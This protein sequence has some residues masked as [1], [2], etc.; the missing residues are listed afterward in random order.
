MDVFFLFLV[1]CFGEEQ[2]TRSFDRRRRQSRTRNLGFI[3]ELRRALFYRE[4]NQ[5]Q[6][7]QN[8]QFTGKLGGLCSQ[9]MAS[10]LFVWFIW[11]GGRLLEAKQF[12]VGIDK[13][14]GTHSRPAHLRHSQCKQQSDLLNCTHSTLFSGKVT[15]QSTF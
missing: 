5:I 12:R 2:T 8:L 13:F 11:E 14:H 7:N 1:E 15:E 9:Y 3:W 4:N 6:R 10:V